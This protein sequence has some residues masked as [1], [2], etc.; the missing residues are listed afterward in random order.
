MHQDYYGLCMTSDK[1]CKLFLRNKPRLP[2]AFCEFGKQTSFFLP[3]SIIFHRLWVLS[4]EIT[5]NSKICFR[6]LTK[7]EAFQVLPLK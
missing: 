7:L 6:K 5:K 3:T 1:A 2:L 4:P